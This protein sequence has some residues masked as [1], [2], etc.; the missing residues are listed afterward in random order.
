MGCHT[1]ASVSWSDSLVSIGSWAFSNAWA[2]TSIGSFGKTLTSLGDSAFE[3]TSLKSVDLSKTPLTSI[4]SYAFDGDSALTSVSLPSGVKSIGDHSFAWSGLTSFT[5]QSGMSLGNA[6]FAGCKS[7]VLSN[8]NTNDYALDSNNNLFSADRKTLWFVSNKEKL[9][10][11]ALTTTIA[12]SAALGR[13]QLKELDLSAVTG[14]ISLGIYAFSQTPSLNKIDWPTASGSR[15]S[16]SDFCFEEADGLT[17]L[18]VPSNVAFL[19][20]IGGATTESISVFASAKN[21]TSLDL[22]AANTTTLGR[23]AFAMCE[24]LKNVILPT[25]LTMIGEMAFNGCSS[26]ES[27][28]L[29]ETLT[30]IES[31]AFTADF[32][33]TSIVIPAKVTRIGMQAFSDCPSLS[34]IYLKATSLPSGYASGWNGSAPYYLYSENEPASSPSKYWHYVNNVPTVYPEA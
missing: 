9:T 29:P 33:L 19:T 25:G 34:G 5:I 13:D 10:V 32:A 30:T 26:L 4:A 21:L 11:P 24:A 23:N 12:D 28:V 31:N 18:I 8:E 27:I 20:T 2:L 1:L 15:V 3:Y 7:L 14:S 17:S 22:S 16:I 6:C